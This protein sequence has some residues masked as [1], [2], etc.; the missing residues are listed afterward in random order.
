[1]ASSAENYQD[2]LEAG[3]CL[4]CTVVSAAF[5]A[6]SLVVAV[7]LIIDAF[8]GLFSE[9]AFYGAVLVLALSAIRVR[10]A[11]HTPVPASLPRQP[12]RRGARQFPRILSRKGDNFREDQGRHYRRADQRA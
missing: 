4:R 5:A 2:H 9:A 8:A 6:V 3:D 11:P 10:L 12:R 7:L 1:M